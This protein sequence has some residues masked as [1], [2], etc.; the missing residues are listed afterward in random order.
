MYSLRPIRNF[1]LYLFFFFINF[2]ELKILNLD[3]FSIPK[4]T[5]VLY[6]LTVLPQL[7]KFIGVSKIKSLLI[8]I[9]LFFI[10]L[11]VISLLNIS[12]S[13]FGFFDFGLFQNIIL[14]WFLINHGLKEP[15]R[16]E[17]AMLSLAL[18]SVLLA[19]L[20]KAGIG[21]E[22]SEEGRITMFGD[23]QNIIG[24]RMTIAISILVFAV[25]QNRLRLNKLRYLLLLPIPIMLEL[26]AVTASRVALISFVLCLIVG[27]LFFKTKRSWVKIAAFA[28]GFVVLL[29][30]YQF[31]MQYETL[32]LRLLQS[33][34]G[35]DLAGRS[36]IYE[37]VWPVI[38]D[39]PIF[40]I[41]ETG[42]VSL[43]GGMSPH[44]VFL[45]VLSYTGSVG[46]LVYLT[47]LFLIFRCAVKSRRINGNILP[48][49]LL[50]PVAGFLI[51][52]Q[53]LTQKMGWVIFAYCVTSTDVIIRKQSHRNTFASTGH[54]DAISIV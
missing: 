15:L 40:G 33:Y 26:M 13:S 10:L 52:G 1:S 24:L 30:M 36:E 7:T 22:Y 28:V 45:E 20:Y 47:F 5:G 8:A 46:L 3:F 9:W 37:T 35:G 43:F 53:I 39:N 49:L 2:Q 48:I 12:E 6:L 34:E 42:Y 11:T 16:L 54:T 41:G 27:I 51:S 29:F 19:V 25:L 50:I 44:N 23:N 31:F 32:I 4:L 21:I 18:G 14:F 17:K 38:I